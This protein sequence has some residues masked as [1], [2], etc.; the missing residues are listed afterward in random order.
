MP[1]FVR[2]SQTELDSVRK[3][4]ESVMSY[5]CHGLFFRE[6]IAL[7]DQ[8]ARE[9]EAGENLLSGARTALVARGWVEDIEFREG[10]ARARG[11]AEV[12]PGSG[13]ETCHRLR[14][15]VS[16]VYE[17]STKKRVRFA[18]VECASKGAKKCVFAKE[19]G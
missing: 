19:A 7:A 10:E 9:I 3:L 6:G 8:I 4:Y 13:A 11:S 5:A 14:G 12:S 16:R 15:I 1:R 18:E 2:I 17:L